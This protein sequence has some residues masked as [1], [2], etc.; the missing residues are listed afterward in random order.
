MRIQGNQNYSCVVQDKSGKNAATLIG[1]WNENM[2]FVSEDCSGKG[3]DPFT[4]ANLLWRRCKPLK[5][6]TR[7][8]LT[9]FAFTLNELTPGLKG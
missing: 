5:V 2:H 9:R 4:D 3:K 6:P 8:N 1:K 7:Y